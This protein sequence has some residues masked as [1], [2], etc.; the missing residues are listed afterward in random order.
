MTTSLSRV[1]IALVVLASPAFAQTPATG[2]ASS[3]APTTGGQFSV[4][5]FYAGPRIWLGNLNGAVAIGGQ[6]EKGFTPAGKY[7]PGIIG[8]G[9][10]ID[11]YKWDNDYSFG[12]YNYSVI[13]IQIF[14]N[15]HFVIESNKKLDPYAGL[16]F[17]YS[18]VNASWEGSGAAA[19]ADGNYT[20]I[21]GQ[22]GVRYFLTEKMAVQGQIGFGYGTLGIG[23][24]W[25]F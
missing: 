11:Y 23:A 10:G 25:K 2:S 5:P 7:G 1:V 24:T 3:P 20:D 4:G 12:Q 16:A 15:Y 22:A 19:T 18:I 9:V 17:V 13:P 6:I 21:A 8:G 14:G